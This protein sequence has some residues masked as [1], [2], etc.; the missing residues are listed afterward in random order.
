MPNVPIKTGHTGP[1]YSDVLI[2]IVL[3]DASIVDLFTPSRW[4]T[5]QF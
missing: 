3:T 5:R 4:A 1:C 2:Y